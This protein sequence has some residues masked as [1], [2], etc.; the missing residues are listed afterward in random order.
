MTTALFRSP[1]FGPSRPVAERDGWRRYVALGDSITEGL[2]DVGP[3]GRLRGWADRLAELL[4]QAQGGPI[5][6][7]NLAVRGSVSAHVYEEQLSVALAMEPDV[8]TVV[9]GVNDVLRPRFDVGRTMFHLESTWAQLRAAGV[10]VLSFTFPDITSMMPVPPHYSRR[11]VML[12]RAIRAGAARRGVLLADLANR[13]FALHPGFWA[14]DRVHCNEHGHGRIAAAMA[15][16]LGLRGADESWTTPLGPLPE[17][18]ITGRVRSHVGW[19][20]GEL[21]PW[22]L[23]AAVKGDL[24]ERCAA[25]HTDLVTV[26]RPESALVA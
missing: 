6:Y 16:R 9:A 13:P 25:K 18:G 8:A 12:N 24:R 22:V 20:Y 15:Q 14:P 19:A 26:G 10:T 2:W 4:A 17:Q 11:V 23:R 3:D 7:A 1:Q 5:E 21:L